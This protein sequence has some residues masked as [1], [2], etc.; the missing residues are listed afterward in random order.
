MG[1]HE[2]EYVG[3]EDWRRHKPYGAGISR[4]RINFIKAGS[5]PA[6]PATTSTTSTDVSSFYLNLVL[7]GPKTTPGTPNSATDATPTAMATRAGDEG[8][9]GLTASTGR[10]EED[11]EVAVALAED[12]HLHPICDTC[13]LPIHDPE[14]HQHTLAHQSSLP[15]SEL[16]HHLD[17]SSQGLKYLISRGWD[18]D[19]K[20]GLG[21]EGAEGDRVP[22]AVKLKPKHDTVGL[23]VKVKDKDRGKRKAKGSHIGSEAKVVKKLDAKSARKEAERERE[24]RKAL[25]EYLNRS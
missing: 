21:K 10:E 1:D 5:A 11:E 3:S 15:H 9:V 7:K 8:R 23:G 12:T 20:V 24:R 13:S 25:A 19:R 2:E 6:T 16:P 18:P 14:T 17:R 4:K 22:M